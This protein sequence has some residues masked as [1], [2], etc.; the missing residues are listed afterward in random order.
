V[1][2]GSIDWPLERLRDYR[3]ELTAPDDFEA[4]W[5]RNLEQSATVPLNAEFTE[6]QG[7]LPGARIYDAAFD[8]V[9][10]VRVRGWFL[11]PLD[12]ATALPVLVRFIGYS[13]GRA[14]AHTNAHHVL[15][16]FCVFVMD[17]RGQ[18]GHTGMR[19][20]TSHGARRGFITHGI[21][22]PDEY[23]FRAF[24][25]DTVRAVE[26]VCGRSEVDPDRVAVTGG[27]QGGALTIA[28]A[29]LSERVKV[30]AP[31]VPWLSHFERA[32]DIAVGPYEEITDFMKAYPERV[33]DAFRTLAYFDNMN[34]VTRTQV[35]EAYYS[36]GLW[37]DICPPSTVF[38]SYNHLPDPVERAIEIYR[39]NKHE[40]GGDL[41]EQRKMKW[42]RDT[43]G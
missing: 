25:L 11:T 3:P 24:Y 4:F 32:V 41:H 7:N 18:G 10:G 43:L 27:S 14:Y 33:D 9:D 37:D 17:S 23:Y 35:A 2:V 12:T 42:L 30:M 28:C 36:V 22:D 38:A 26:A 20:N 15:N 5:R 8:G 40:G 1:I 13:G 34:L 29:S 6:L 16:G 19:L 39:Y 31:D 21:L